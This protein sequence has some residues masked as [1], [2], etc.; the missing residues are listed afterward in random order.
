[1]LTC[2]TVVLIFVIVAP[3]LIEQ[4]KVFPYLWNLLLDLLAKIGLVSR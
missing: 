2:S 1:M 3:L 4:I